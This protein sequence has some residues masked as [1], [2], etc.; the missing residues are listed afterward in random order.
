M[1]HGTGRERQTSAGPST[2]PSSSLVSSLRVALSDPAL[3][4]LAPAWLTIN[5]VVG[6]W[7]TLAGP[8][9]ASPQ[10]L[11]GQYLVGRFT[12]TQVGGV[13]L[14]YVVVLAIGVTAWGYILSYVPRV[15]ALR[16]ALSAMLV[17]CLLLFLLN[18]S[19]D[20]PDAW[21]WLLTP[22]AALAVMVESGFTP[23]AL[24]YL[25]DVIG[26]SKGRGAA[27]G[28]YMTLMG[29]G[30]FLGLAIGG[31]FSALALNGLVLG[32]VILALAGLAAVAT[33][34]E[35]GL[36]SGQ[37]TG[38]NGGNDKY[39]TGTIQTHYGGTDG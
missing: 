17:V 35:V 29:L 7:L 30:G 19:G 4:R 14:A 9:L 37:R 2:A 16:I 8:I 21:R 25:A 1:Q 39:G 38:H 5:A 15:R 24:S 6:L 27:M 34:P 28:I 33:L 20:W 26:E 36:A 13:I 31:I 12:P 32:T 18:S 3:R 10:T 22:V 11:Q 23:A